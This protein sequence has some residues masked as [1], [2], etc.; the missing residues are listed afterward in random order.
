MA[1]AFQPGG[2]VET[3][4][5]DKTLVTAARL[6][7]IQERTLAAATRWADEYPPF[8]VWVE[9]PAAYGRQV[10]P[11]LQYAVGVVQQALYQ[12]LFCGSA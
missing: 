12:A 4:E 5:F 9:Q 6:D 8:F 11:Q 3:V 2:H 1:V 10:E 7:D